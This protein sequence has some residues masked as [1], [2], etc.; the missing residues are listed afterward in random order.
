MS[1]DGV[2]SSKSQ[3]WLEECFAEF[4][5]F[6]R[7][8]CPVCCSRNLTILD[9]LCPNCGTIIAKNR[10]PIDKD[11]TAKLAGGLTAGELVVRS[12]KWWDHIGRQYYRRVRGRVGDSISL[13]PELRQRGILMGKK[14]D[15]LNR[16]EKFA[17]CKAYHLAWFQKET[18]PPAGVAPIVI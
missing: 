6:G 17:V 10:M 2:Q 14:F 4:D 8:E 1:G 9:I 18:D 15:D 12:K 3:A 7:V 11:R 13:T 16:Q 5:T